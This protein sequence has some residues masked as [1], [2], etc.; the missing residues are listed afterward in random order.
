VLLRAPFRPEPL[1]DTMRRAGVR[2]YC[3]PEGEAHTA[4]FARA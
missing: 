4:Y 2:V 3:T 1:L